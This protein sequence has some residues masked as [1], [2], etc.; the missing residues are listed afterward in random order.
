MYELS[1]RGELAWFK[2][3]IFMGS[4]EDEYVPYSSAILEDM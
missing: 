2:T 4:K 1:E 3:V